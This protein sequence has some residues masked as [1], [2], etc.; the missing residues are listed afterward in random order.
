MKGVVDLQKIYFLDG[1]AVT[2]TQ[3]L[4]DAEATSLKTKAKNKK[5]LRE[6][7]IFRPVEG[8]KTWGEFMGNCQL[9]TYNSVPS[10][11]IKSIINRALD[12]RGVRQPC[13]AVFRLSGQSFVYSEK[14]QPIIYNAKLLVD[15]GGTWYKEEDEYGFI[16]DWYLADADADRDIEGEYLLTEK[17]DFPNEMTEDWQELCLSRYGQVCDKYHIV[18]AYP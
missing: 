15:R 13:I 11:N 6:S 12:S 16:T 18:P 5:R 9:I 4:C 8:Y 7:L 14:G 10:I 1:K 2:K 3:L 17:V